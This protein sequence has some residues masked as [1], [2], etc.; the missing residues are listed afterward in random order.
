ME[1]CLCSLRTSMSKKVSRHSD[2]W[3]CYIFFVSICA[4]FFSVCERKF[5][6]VYA[7]ISVEL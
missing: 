7:A 1:S 4:V 3:A 6:R 5:V 2:L